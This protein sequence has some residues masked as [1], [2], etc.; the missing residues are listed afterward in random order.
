MKEILSGINLRTSSDVLE[1]NSKF[2]IA[3]AG[4]SVIGK[5]VL[6]AL[7]FAKFKIDGYDFDLILEEGRKLKKE[8]GGYQSPA[9][10][11][12]M[13]RQQEREELR[14]N[15]VNGFITDTPLFQFYASARYNSTGSQRDVHILRELY[16]MCAYELPENRYGLIILMKDPYKNIEYKID[17]SRRATKTE[18]NERNQ[19]TINLVEHLWPKKVLYVNGTSEERVAQVFKHVSDL[20]ILR[21]PS[22]AKQK[23]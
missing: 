18:S 9:D 13:W 14:S 7:L 10:R 20:N 3:I 6:A 23:R 16:R 22:K 15:A 8:F 21:K 11:L 4:G 5:S 2:N 12:Y 19:L 1:E 17:N